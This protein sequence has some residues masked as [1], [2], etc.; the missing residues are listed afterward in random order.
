VFFPFFF[1]LN[2]FFLF[3][4][5]GIGFG[6]Y[7]MVMRQRA[8][9]E[10]AARHGLDPNEAAATTFLG[11]GGLDATYLAANLHDARSATPLAQTGITPASNAAHKV[12]ARLHELAMLKQ[13]GVITPDEY[14]ARRKAIIDEI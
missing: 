2:F 9:R 6:I 3:W 13:Q 4:A 10:I 14:E 1:P 5:I 7:R 8:A 12:E 11:Q